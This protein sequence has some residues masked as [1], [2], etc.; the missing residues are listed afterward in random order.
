MDGLKSRMEGMEEIVSALEDSRIEITGSEKTEN[1]LKKIN[2]GTCS[3][4]T[5]NWKFVPSESQKEKRAGLKKY[6]KK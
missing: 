3:T 4:I 1:R 6:S 2:L 5:K